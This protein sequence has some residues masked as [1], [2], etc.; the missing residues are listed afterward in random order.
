MLFPKQKKYFYFS[1]KI[2]ELGFV[3]NQIE[4]S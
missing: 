2:N 1:Q 4:M 3:L